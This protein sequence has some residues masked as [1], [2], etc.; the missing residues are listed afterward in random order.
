MLSSDRP[1]ASEDDDV[2]GFSQFADALARSLTEMAP[3]EGIVVSI[4]GAWGA[5]KTSALNER[6]RR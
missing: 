4:E 2:L 1:I 5:G 3:D 6:D